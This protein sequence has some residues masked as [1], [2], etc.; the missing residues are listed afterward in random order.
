[1]E[2]LSRLTEMLNRPYANNGELI[3]FVSH[4]G[5]PPGLVTMQAISFKR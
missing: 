3:G 2:A 1:M 5:Q 4:F